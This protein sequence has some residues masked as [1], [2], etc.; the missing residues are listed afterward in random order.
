M[1]KLFHRQKLIGFI[2]NEMP[3]NAQMVG[4]IELT[5]AAESNRDVF[6]FFAHDELDTEEVS[7]F[8]GNLVE[9]WLLEDEG[10]KRREIDIPIVYPDGVI[11]WR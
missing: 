2:T 6:A 1:L 11:C 8:S 7:P 3:G 10:G 4:D 9:G 5:P